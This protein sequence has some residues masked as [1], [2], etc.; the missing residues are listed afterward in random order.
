MGKINVEYVSSRKSVMPIWCVECNQVVE[1]ELTRGEFIYPRRP[2]LAEITLWQCPTCK[3]SVGT[4]RNSIDPLKPLGVISNKEMRQMKVEI[5]NLLDP[6]WKRGIMS[7]NRVYKHISD[8]LGVQYHTGEIRT[9]EEAEH[10]RSIVRR[11]ISNLRSLGY[12]V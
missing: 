1:A 4:H 8:E 2:D 9:I 12:E 7:R 10:V 5:H 3:N 11:L 6:I